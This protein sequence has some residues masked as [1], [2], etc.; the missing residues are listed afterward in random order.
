MGRGII[1]LGNHY[2]EWSTI[3]DAPI[4]YGMT[5]DEL[6]DYVKS[7]CGEEGLRHLPERLERADRTGTSFV[8]LT[9]GEVVRFNRA[10]DNEECLSFKKLY[11]KYVT[12]ATTDSPKRSDTQAD[13]SPNE[14]KS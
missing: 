2:L 3:V 13:I 7:E 11:E 10:G 5:L 8:G 14:T 12:E 1:K 9:V 6:R 4:T